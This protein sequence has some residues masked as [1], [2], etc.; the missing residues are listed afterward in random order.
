MTE[1]EL[2]CPYCGEKMVR[3][4]IEME[5]GEW[6]AVWLCGCVGEDEVTKEAPDEDSHLGG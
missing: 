4:R 5:G 2:V 1:N 6:L 3:G